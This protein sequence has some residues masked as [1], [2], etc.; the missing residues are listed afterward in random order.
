MSNAPP[1]VFVY[2]SGHVNLDRDHEI[3][4][5]ILRRMKEPDLDASAL[6]RSLTELL[7]YLDAH[8]EH[9][10]DLMNRYDYPEAPAHKESH[11][12]IRTDVERLHCCC[13]AGAM[14]ELVCALDLWIETHMRGVDAQLAAF[15]RTCEVER[16][17]ADIDI[18]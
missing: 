12:E 8:F 7:A 1:D 16:P 4:I 5:T 10:E 11:R 18:F 17:G 2:G 9:E 13:P 15:L 6:Q 14:Q 3:L